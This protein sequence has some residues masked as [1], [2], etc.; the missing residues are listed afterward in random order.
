MSTPMRRK[1][2]PRVQK[3]IK[4]K[5]SNSRLILTPRVAVRQNA[6][7]K[8]RAVRTFSRP[9]PRRSPGS[10]QGLVVSEWSHN[11]ENPF[12]E[13]ASKI[14]DLVS[15]PPSCLMGTI[16]ITNT[17]SKFTWPTSTNVAV[18][19]T[20]SGIEYNSSIDTVGQ[21]LIVQ[22][23][24]CVMSPASFLLTPEEANTY[25]KRLVLRPIM[26]RGC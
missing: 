26:V 23:F 6:T 24:P 10:F 11:V 2:A 5:T 19:V 7:R 9:L 3:L 4:K 18:N 21:Q 15:G 20:D 16:D 13:G 17:F 8:R 14:P 25:L 12:S 1:G 22:F